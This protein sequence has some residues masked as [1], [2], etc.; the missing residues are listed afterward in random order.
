MEGQHDGRAIKTIIPQLNPRQVVSLAVNSLPTLRKCHILT[1][2]F[3]LALCCCDVQI[4]LRSH[5]AATD[6]LLINLHAITNLT[7]EISAPA[8][9]EQVMIGEQT[10]SYSISLSEG[11]M[12][13]A[14]GRWSKVSL[15]RV[16]LLKLHGLIFGADTNSSRTTRWPRSA[17]RCT[18]GRI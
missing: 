16:D 5:K 17:A 14:Q 11:L 6:D 1:L 9:Y 13:D 10:Q 8:D 15:G 3:R 2:G 4:L 12:T 18:S 7:K